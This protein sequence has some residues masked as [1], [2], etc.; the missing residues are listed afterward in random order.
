MGLSL[1]G[2]VT[3]KTFM[4][5]VTQ[6][7]EMC[8]YLVYHT[9]DSRRSAKGF[10]DLVIAGR[11]KLIAAELKV[12]KNQMTAAQREWLATLRAVPGVVAVEWRPEQFDEI[13][14]ALQG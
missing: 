3:E 8:G 6:L 7:A 9:H 2:R 13:V 11:G 5:Q 4:A 14:Q 12:G 1:P 10:P